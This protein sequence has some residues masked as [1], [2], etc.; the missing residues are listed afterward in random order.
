MPF[1]SL[2]NQMLDQSVQPATHTKGEPISPDVL[3]YAAY[4]YRLGSPWREITSETGIS[5]STLRRHL[6]ASGVTFRGRSAPRV[7]GQS[8]KGSGES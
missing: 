1:Q 5:T 2:V 8:T 4:R 3:R 7:R 6:H